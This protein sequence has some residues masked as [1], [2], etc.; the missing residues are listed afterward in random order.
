MRFI[1][2]ADLLIL[3]YQMGYILVFMR[4]VRRG[5]EHK[6]QK[7]NS[8]WHLWLYSTVV[9]GVLAVVFEVTVF[10]LQ[11]VDPVKLAHENLDDWVENLY[12]NLVPSLVSKMFLYRIMAQYITLSLLGSLRTTRRQLDKLSKKNP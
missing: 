5:F 9:E 4:Y 8:D 1:A 6:T 12:F 7:F 10:P 3:T 2:A 11:L